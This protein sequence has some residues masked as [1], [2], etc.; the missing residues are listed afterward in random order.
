[1]IGGG[2][3]SVGGKHYTSNPTHSA[4]SRFHRICP[5]L[6]G[7]VGRGLFRCA[8]GALDGIFP[9]ALTSKRSAGTDDVRALIA[10]VAKHRKQTV[11][12]KYFTQETT[13]GK[14]KQRMRP[15]AP[16]HR[17]G[18]RGGSKRHCHGR[19]TVDG[20]RARIPH[21]PPTISVGVPAM[22]TQLI[23]AKC[24][25]PASGDGLRQPCVR[26]QNF[27]R[28]RTQAALLQRAPP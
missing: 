1:L 8:G 6:D 12:S 17:S 23:F 19:V 13:S 21:R 11:H 22:R 14:S 15:M 3:W 25:R 18:R 20:L 28:L 9:M 7:G 5:D 10:F 16:F 2:S 27:V 26:G 24:S 4:Q